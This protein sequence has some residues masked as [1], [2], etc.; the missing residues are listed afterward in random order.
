MI[1]LRGTTRGVALVVVAS[2]AISTGALII[3][4]RSAS[5][6]RN[7]AEAA[8]TK[9][10]GVWLRDF[11]DIS[12]ELG[13]TSWHRIMIPV[14]SADLRDPDAA[15]TE[16]LRT[17][18]ELP[19]DCGCARV[20]PSYVFLVDMSTLAISIAGTRTAAA[21]DRAR[22]RISKLDRAFREARSDPMKIIAANGS[23]S[24][25]DWIIEYRRFDLQ[26]RPIVVGL[27][28]PL[29]RIGQEV[30]EAAHR[31]MLAAYRSNESDTVTTFSLV[32]THLRG[33][34][35]YASAPQF[36]GGPT[37]S[38]RYWDDSNPSM[39][40][41]LSLNSRTFAQVVPGGI[42][43]VPQ[44]ML[45]SVAILVAAL[46]VLG[47]FLL[48]RANELS[49]VREQFAASVTHE[50]RT[51]LTQ[52][53]LYAESLQLGR[54]GDHQRS[55]SVIARESK[56]LIRLVDNV[57]HL[58]KV[59]RSSP[60][61]T[62]SE[63][64]LDVAVAATVAGLE[65]L[66][67][68][69]GMRIEVSVPSELTVHADAAALEQIVRNLIDNAI[70]YGSADQTISVSASQDEKHVSLLVADEGPGIAE[71]NRERIWQPYVRLGDFRV[72]GGGLG[73]GLAIARQMADAM[74]A[75]LS[76]RTG[77]T[78]GA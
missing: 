7:S 57:M 42:P 69:R 31:R 1:S 47:V 73:L 65:P 38:L 60:Q 9:V 68:E 70:R 45:V 66:A 24:A 29:D 2:L 22:A 17:A 50:I 67:A 11:L 46:G 58:A 78:S 64:D 52:I 77:T 25:G 51:P 43:V 61:F 54:T 19:A 16:M 14:F 30:M 26:G 6:A 13:L 33:K 4:W 74:G 71:Q 20:I 53:L 62:L 8:A 28:V 32:V 76:V 39:V 15:L 63:V 48:H 3:A 44:T 41:A 23:D 59:S 37:V 35:L 72:E 5:S 55:A 10:A 40:A 12:S 56:R 75:T 34:Q 49:A 21:T 27:E 36:T 18:R